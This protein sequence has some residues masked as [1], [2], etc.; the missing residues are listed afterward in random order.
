MVDLAIKTLLHDRLRFVITI[1]GVAFAVLL[2]FVQLGLFH[3][4]LDN[5]SI[6]I[7]HLDADLWVTSRNVPNIDFAQTFPDTY[8]QR[9]RSVPG[10]ARAA[11]LIVWFVPV[12]LPSGAQE[13]L[14][15]YALEDFARW[16]IPWSVLEGDVKDLRRGR[17]VMLD[18]SATRRYGPFRIDDYREILGNRLKIIG[19]TVGAKSFTTNPVGFVDYS[20]AQELQP[21]RLRGQ[22]TYVLV[23]LAP[24]ADIVAVRGELRRRL[25]YNDVHTRDEWAH[26]SRAYWVRS[27]GLGLNMFVTVGLGCLVGTIVLAQTL[28]SATM[29]H[30][31]EFATAKAIGAS[32]GLIYRV[33]LKQANVAAVHGFSVV[34]CAALALRPLMARIDLNLLVG[35]GFAVVVFIGALLMCWAAAFVSFGKIASIDPA[36]VFRQ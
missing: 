25:P 10:V 11:N 27:T 26:L 29:E 5:A 15:I 21:D 23:K 2:V 35:P 12:T 33:L 6:M 14:E 22:T 3:G 19:R 20:T 32:N 1:L 7:D 17:Y 16:G 36:A 24:G 13:P 34:A 18:D 31:R 30:F 9:A 8:M 4:V 28:Y